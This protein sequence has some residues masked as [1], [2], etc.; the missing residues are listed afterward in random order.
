M[1][2]QPVDASRGFEGSPLIATKTAVA[3]TI[4]MSRVRTGRGKAT[5]VPYWTSKKGAEIMIIRGSRVHIADGY[6]TAWKELQPT[7]P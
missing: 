6:V 2:S 4:L 7:H 5:D 1:E 3:A